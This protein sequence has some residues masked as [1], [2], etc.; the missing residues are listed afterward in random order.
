MTNLQMESLP[1]AAGE[2][3]K[4]GK[5]DA[6]TSKG[7]EQNKIKIAAGAGLKVENVMLVLVS[8]LEIL[9]KFHA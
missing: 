1:E 7:R 5:A 2:E 4:D 6:D 3:S 8:A 9:S